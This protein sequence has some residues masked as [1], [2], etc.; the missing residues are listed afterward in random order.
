MEKM[1]SRI[2]FSNLRPGMKINFEGYWNLIKTVTYDSSS[3]E[4]EFETGSKMCVPYSNEL[5]KQIVSVKYEVQ[6]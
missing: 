5:Y 3:I 2:L 4:I 1:R 6:S